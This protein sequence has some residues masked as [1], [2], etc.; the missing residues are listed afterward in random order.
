DARQEPDLAGDRPD[1]ARVAPVDAASLA[2]HHLTDDVRL[3]V[4]EL[5]FDE[6]RE[7]RHPLGAELRGQRREQLLLD[8]SVRL[9]ALL[10]L[11]DHAG[12]LELR[13]AEL[14]DALAHRLVER[15]DRELALGA[16][17]GLLHALDE[18]RSEERRVGKEC[19]CG[20]GACDLI[21][22]ESGNSNT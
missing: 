11:A 17:D 22:S 16:A 12:D 2:Q 13:V 4:L 18:V 20:P 9:V 5:L 1:R 6:A 19:R 14:G 15:G 7:L 3:A 10:L 8:L 21:T